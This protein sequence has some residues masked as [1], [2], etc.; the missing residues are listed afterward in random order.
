M[1]TGT[2]TPA[3]G[4]ELEFVVQEVRDG[5][6]RVILRVGGR[7]A[8]KLNDDEQEEFLREYLQ[9]RQAALGVRRD[10]QAGRVRD[11]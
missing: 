9:A 10:L 2:M 6:V 11:Y 4:V 1:I 8:A 5:D 3:D 7:V